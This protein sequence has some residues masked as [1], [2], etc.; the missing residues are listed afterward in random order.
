MLPQWPVAP[1][2]PRYCQKNW[3]DCCSLR[4]L[5]P[6]SGK[7]ICDRKI[8]PMKGHIRRFVNENHDVVSAEDMEVALESHGGLKGCR[9]AVVEVDS[10]KDLFEGNKIPDI[11]LLYNFQ[12]ETGGIRV[13]KA[14]EVGK[15]KLLTYK[16]HQIQPQEVANL[17]VV[18]PFG[19]RQN[20]CGSIS[21]ASKATQAEIFSCSETTCILTFRSERE[22]QAH[23]DTGK[24]VRELE[25]VS[26]YDEI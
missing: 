2:P 4:L 14:Y 21:N 16:A 3:Y 10:S 1:V 23:M 20:E 24:H 26:L 19:P 12:Y 17:K 11:S 8:A 18:K 22:A 5:R 9:A 25:S 13:W 6:Q 7:D 15:G